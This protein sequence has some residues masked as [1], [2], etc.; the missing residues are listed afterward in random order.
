ML[1]GTL[2]KQPRIKN[3]FYCLCNIKQHPYQL[4]NY[5]HW[6]AG[7][8]SWKIFFLLLLGSFLYQSPCPSLI[9]QFRTLELADCWAKS[10]FM[11]NHVAALLNSRIGK[12]DNT[13]GIVTL[14]RSTGLASHTLRL[15][16]YPEVVNYSLSLT[17]KTEP[18]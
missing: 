18:S 8:Y 17:R 4:P 6:K 2:P 13:T 16:V 9:S 3:F 14:V 10:S 15:K 5:R 11:L 12:D 7:K 1:G